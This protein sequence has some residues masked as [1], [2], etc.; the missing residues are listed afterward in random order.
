MTIPVAHKPTVT[1]FMLIFHQG[2]SAYWLALDGVEK[3]EHVLVAVSC[4]P[5]DTP[6]EEVEIAA[7]R[8]L[9]LGRTKIA[10]TRRVRPAAHAEEGS[11]A[12]VTPFE[13][14]WDAVIK[15]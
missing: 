6:P 10:W 13:D 5:S 14:G 3:G 8:I 7:R 9:K 2:T 1:K 12:P 11:T 15:R 4:D